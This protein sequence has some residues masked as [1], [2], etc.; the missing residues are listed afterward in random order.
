MAASPWRRLLPKVVALA[1]PRAT[2]AEVEALASTF[3]AGLAASTAKQYAYRMHNFI[4]FCVQHNP[5]LAFM[6]AAR[7]S[8]ILW[9]THLAS[10]GTVD[11]TSYNQYVSS[12]NSVHRLLHQTP[13]V[14]DK[15]PLMQ[16]LLRGFVRT[17]QPEERQEERQPLPVTCIT[18]IVQ[19]G[20][21]AQ[22][23]ARAHTP[24]RGCGAGFCLRATRLQHFPAFEQRPHTV[25]RPFCSCCILP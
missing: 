5:P 4:T 24:V 11:S 12:I 7:E 23:G 13:P 3:D 25:S 9:L 15:D 1:Y 19:A 14:P 8:V 6:P 2:P 22:G 21:T 18:A 20:L 17:V 16:L 10:S